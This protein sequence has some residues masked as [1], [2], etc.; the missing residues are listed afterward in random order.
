M[1]KDIGALMMCPAYAFG[2]HAGVGQDRRL[3]GHLVY[4]EGLHR[5]EH[6]LHLPQQGCRGQ[7]RAQETGILIAR[8]YQSNEMRTRNPN[9]SIIDSLRSAMGQR[10][11]FHK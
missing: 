11:T 2:A 8:L 6:D 10:L 3:P 9:T 5:P 1:K 4:D 7:G